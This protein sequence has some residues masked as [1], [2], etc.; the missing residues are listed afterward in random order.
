MRRSLFRSL[1]ATLLFA[2]AGLTCFTGCP[3]P[4]PQENAAESNGSGGGETGSGESS[5]GDQA[6]A[7]ETTPDDPAVVERLNA[8]PEVKLQKNAAGNITTID[9]TNVAGTVD[10]SDVRGG[11][12]EMLAGLEG[13]PALETVVCFGPG[14]G[15]AG[16]EHLSKV[17]TLKTINLMPRSGVADAGV[18]ALAKLP[19]LENLY[20]QQSDITDETLKSLAKVPTLKRLRVIRTNITDEGLKHLAACENLELL[21][22]K[23]C[24]YIYEMGLAYIKDLKKLR[25]LTPGNN[26]ISD[27]SMEYVSGLTN[28]VA[29][30]LDDGSLSDEGM[31]H[32][33]NLTKLRELYLTRTFVGDAGLQYVSQMPEME[34]LSLRASA[35]TSAGM[36]H[37]SGLKKLK[38]LDLS[39]C[40]AV[41]DEGMADLAPITSLVD[42]N[43]WSTRVG[44][45]G[46]EHIAALKN[47]ESLNLDKTG[48]TDAGMKFVGQ[49]PKV[50]FM[51]LGTTKI[52]DEG[53]K[54]LTG[55][56]NLE[57]LVVTH[58]EGVTQAG[59][60]DLKQE[61]PSLK[62]VEL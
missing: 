28:L 4:S 44:D 10:G 45:A 58:C 52:T 21:D 27:A 38:E 18:A 57:T 54:Q 22:M 1:A 9:F 33:A 37:L 39:E 16:M 47:L 61:L 25:S 36:K 56:K 7:V 30:R 42:L 3:A 32:L 6:T 31:K 29:L 43:L 41:A 11:T 26:Q 46:V 49:L 53:L 48:L 55:M 50:E 20:M 51:H 24:Q 12:D 8:L 60:D 23:E 14:I 17:A 2:G 13:L 40:F 34:K 5:G 15:D 19:K 35:V 62:T 59:V